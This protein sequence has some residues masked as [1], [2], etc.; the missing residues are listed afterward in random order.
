MRVQTD[1]HKWGFKPKMLVTS[2]VWV[3]LAIFMFVARIFAY[4]VPWGLLFLGIAVIGPFAPTRREG[5]R[6]K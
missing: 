3:A 6:Y 4:S 5:A 2:V 1:P